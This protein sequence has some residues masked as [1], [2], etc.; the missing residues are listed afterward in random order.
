MIRLNPT[1]VFCVDRDEYYRRLDDTDSGEEEA[2]LRWCRYV[3]GGLRLELKKIDRLL[4]FD[5]LRTAIL[6]PT[7]KE[8]RRKA[9]LGPHEETV[10]L[11]SLQH[12]PLQKQDVAGAIPSIGEV[13]LPRIISG[14]RDSRY[15]LPTIEGGR[16]YMLDI[17]RNPLFREVLKKLD[18]NGFLP[19]K[20]EL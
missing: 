16:K 5:Y 3:L 11:K 9:V 1:A 14:L 19:I 13:Q 15:L 17:T 18:E 6:Q 7:I 12:V 10:L 2:L 20:G 4:D 8:L